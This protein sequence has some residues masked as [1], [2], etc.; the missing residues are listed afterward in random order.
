MQRV[1]RDAQLVLSLHVQMLQRNLHGVIAGS[2]NAGDIGNVFTH[3]NALGG[4]AVHI[5]GNQVG[6]CVGVADLGLHRGEV[7]VVLIADDLEPVCGR[8]ALGHL[9]APVGSNN[10]EVVVGAV[11]FRFHQ[12]VHNALN[13]L[14]AAVIHGGPE[15]L[16]L[17]LGPIGKIGVVAAGG[18]DQGRFALHG[19]LILGQAHDGQRREAGYAVKRGVQLHIH[20]EDG[21]VNGDGLSVGEHQILAHL[22][23]VSN[24]AVG[25]IHHIHIGY[26]VVVGVIY[27]VILTRLAGEGL[28]HRS[29]HAVDAVHAA[30]HQPQHLVLVIVGV[31]E[32]RELAVKVRGADGEGVQLAL[33]RLVGAVAAARGGVGGGAGGIAVVAAGQQAETHHQRKQKRQQFFSVFHLLFLLDIFE[34]KNL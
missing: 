2:L 6:Q 32:A 5:L 19:I 27:A 8:G 4:H 13:E 25:I 31:E 26:T 28:Q 11:G 18:A 34:R 7:P 21:V 9:K 33:L 29:A 20:R 16:L 1:D 15:G 22:E 10:R 24:G 12:V 23:L 14:R 17:F 30:A 3:R